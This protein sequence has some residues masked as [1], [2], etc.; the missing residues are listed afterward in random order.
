MPIAPK[1]GLSKAPPAILTRHTL[2]T[3]DWKDDVQA[4]QA[5]IG[6]F[7]AD[8]PL[9]NDCQVVFFEMAHDRHLHVNVMHKHPTKEVT[10]WAGPGSVA[11]GVVHNRTF[12][13]TPP[14]LIIRHI[15]DMVFAAS[16]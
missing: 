5:A 8:R 16:L 7:K 6:R 10:G 4:I 1:N 3:E 12:A 2:L 11:Y 9:T 13:D 15:R 14:H